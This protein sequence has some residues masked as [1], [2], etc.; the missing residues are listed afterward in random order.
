M[1]FSDLLAEEQFLMVIGAWDGISARL[2][3]QAGAR[4]IYVSGSCVSTAIHGG[5]D[6]GLTTMT[7][8]ATRAGQIASVVDVPVMADAD[9]GY[10][11]EFNVR[12]TV[13]EYERQGV[14]AIQ[15]ED[16]TFPKKCGHFEGKSII[17]AA[18][19]ATKVEAAVDARDDDSFLIVARTDAIAVE[20][21]D[22][23]IARAELYREAGADILF[24]EA[25]TDTDQM[26][27]IT[28]EVEG[29]LLANMAAKGR[30]PPIPAADLQSIGYDLAIYPSDAFKAAL[31]TMQ[32]VYEQL[33]T[34]RDQH[35][36]LDT[37]MEWDERDRVTGL[38][39]FD[40]LESKYAEASMEYNERI[41][42]LRDQTG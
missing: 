5:P 25:P 14:A 18:D 39:E 22:V 9:T 21:L 36:I 26:S 3:E 8:M 6:I 7:E 15:L 38:P 37:M 30:T 1:T 40:R 4:S 24:I 31:Q 23:A 32:A 19:F 11:N 12:R 13:T 33:L 16:Q 34:D 27:R 17:P 20:G 10:G 28:R 35:A 29:L 42:Q 2:A 41:N